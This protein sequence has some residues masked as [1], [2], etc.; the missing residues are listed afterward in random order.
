M[1]SKDT[2]YVC[3]K[4][5]VTADE[6][7]SGGG[8][9]L[10]LSKNALKKLAKNKDKPAKEKDGRGTASQASAVSSKK[11]VVKKIEAPPVINM[12]PKGEKKDLQSQPM[13]DAYHPSVVECAWGDWWE[14]S[15]FYGCDAR[16]ALERDASKHEK[17]VMVIPPP[18]ITGSLHLGH[19]LTAAVQ[20][21][22]TRWH[23]MKGHVTLYIPGTDHA[24][25][26]TQSVVEKMLLKEQGLSRHDIGREE[27]V[28]KVW[29]WKE[30]YG[31]KITNQLRFL[32]T[33]VDWQRERFTMDDMLSKAVIEAFNLFHEKKLMYRDLRLGNWSCALKS[34]ISDIEVDYLDIEGRTYLTVK[35]HKGN[36]R[37][38]QGR[39][40]FG[41]LTSFAYPLEGSSEKIVVATTRLETMLGD[42]AVAVH[43]RDPRYT[44]LHGKFVV[45]PFNG[46][47]IP[48]ICDADLVDMTFGTGA[49]KITPAHD[50]ND[51]E[52]GKR[53]NLEF[54]TI[55]T[56]DG[57]INH[58]GGEFEGMMRYDAR[59]AVEDSLKDKGLFIG[60][61]PN[62][63][64]LGLCQRSGDILEPMIT[65]Q[66][67]VN[68][69]G[70]ARRAVDAVRNGE[71]KIIPVEHEKTWY[72]WL[73]NI[74]D[75]CV[76][77]QL[78]WGHQIPAWFA[79]KKGEVLSKN[80]MANNDRWI[81]AR[82]EEA[83]Y[84]KAAKLLGESR[85]DIILERD[86][87]V[88][89]TW[90]SSGLFP[91]SV[92]GW[93]DNTD[94]LKAFYPTSL[95]ETGLDILFFWVARMVMMGLELTDQ[96]PFHTVY[97]HAMV[98]D[99]DG[100]K[101]SKS[102]G[103]V[104]DPLEVI[105][106]CS[107]E[108]LH[109]K[110]DAGNLPVKE[111]HRA[112][113][114]LT[115][116]F[117]EG[118]TECGSDALRFGLLAYTIQGRDVNLD[119][120]RVVGYRQFC[121]KL[122]NATRFALQFMFDFQPSSS[123][124]EDLVSSGSMAIRDKFMI[125]RLMGAFETLNNHFINYKFGDAQ[126]AAYSFWLNDL[127]DVYLELVKPVVYDSSEKNAKTRW[128]AQATLWL[129]IEGGLRLLHPM[130]PFVTEELW[131]RL[132]GRGKLGPDEE[133][134][135]ML[136][137]YPECVHE[138]KN[139]DAETSM[140]V[141]MNIIKACRSLRSSYNINHKVMAT[142]YL[143]IAPSVAH[144]AQSQVSDI[145][146][147]AR[148][149]TVHINMDENE[150]PQAVG[151]VVLDDS[152]TVWMDLA[153]IVDYESEIKKLEKS[154]SKT[155]PFVRTLETKLNANGYAEKVA[156]DVKKDNSEKLESYRKKAAELEA[157][158]ESFKSL[159]GKE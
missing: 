89:D 136:S 63:M 142:F 145:K 76:S 130:M 70:M 104:I 143:K 85:E 152:I 33:S 88:L 53:H 73:E 83:A 147:L 132:P 64:R 131:Q 115:A 123:I 159:L 61:E 56:E 41:T 139:D 32:G 48:I 158:I 23:R 140:A 107:L 137:S 81:V 74:K 44:H 9:P 116:D 113:Q 133:E 154:L 141:T 68:C 108:A 14:K 49:V 71:L 24:G 92:F 126:M 128:A 19:A 51:Y 149:S 91:F 62:K 45:H 11:K 95:L 20:D 15:G 43:P 31:D 75:W 124:L 153:G 4:S 94:D 138:Y 111:V 114:D 80:D 148:A 106:G 77:R 96:L 98:R 28:N 35:T 7:E 5:A 1:A 93:P 25:I 99:K 120:K 16:K 29:Q 150:I 86:E 66:W 50:P 3:K 84:A 82:D 109:A 135:I 69:E 65:P 100:R 119:I 156:E 72:H 134:T 17:F 22:L 18:N 129:A 127:C 155:M 58:N 151:I 105:H 157:A 117:P 42:T 39:Y 125:S 122:W 90:F 54:I 101:M 38:P 112:K 146:T 57:A 110:V 67:Y 59:I 144:C 21:T 60:K 26:A 8:D 30:V 46:R 34:A 2:L 103:N 10:I 13:M 78:W 55:F 37:D 79:S 118:I 121:N 12:T 47:R 40:E 87:D 6:K 36:P 27:F 97:L 52:C 102:L